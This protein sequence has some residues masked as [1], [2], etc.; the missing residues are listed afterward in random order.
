LD[1]V[2]RKNELIEKSQGID[3]GPASNLRKEGSYFYRK[4]AKISTLKDKFF[5]NKTIPLWNDLPLEVKEA[6]SLNNFK[7]GLERQRLFSSE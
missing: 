3:Y 1:I 5:V 2:E 4:P 6:K 7:A